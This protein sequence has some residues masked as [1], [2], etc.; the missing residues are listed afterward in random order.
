MKGSAP[1]LDRLLIG[2][3]AGAA[4]GAVLTTI[5]S[6]FVVTPLLP[7][8]APLVAL[9]LF[10]LLLL[11]LPLTHPPIWFCLRAVGLRGWLGSALAGAVALLVVPILFGLAW[12]RRAPP[13]DVFMSPAFL[14]LLPIG[15][16]AGLVIRVVAHWNVDTQSNGG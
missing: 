13:S 11:T 9:L 15:F 2:L 10:M 4:T 7:S 5:I 6:A 14:L 16:I 1:T 3:V 8:L 12:N